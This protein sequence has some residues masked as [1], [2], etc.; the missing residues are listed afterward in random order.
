LIASFLTHQG[1][2]QK[3]TQQCFKSTLI[4]FL[5]S[6]KCQELAQTIVDQEGF[7]VK[8]DV[9]SLY[10][11]LQAFFIQGSPAASRLL[12]RGSMVNDHVE[13]AFQKIWMVSHE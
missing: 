5:A 7:L 4:E 6:K 9:E 11:H 1:Q 3:I 10:I 8:A 13:R 12:T 2:D